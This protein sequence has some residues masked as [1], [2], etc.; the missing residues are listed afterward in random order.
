MQKTVFHNQSVLDC[1]LQQTGS[2]KKLF[3]FAV[4]NNTS[5]TDE[6]KAGNVFNFPEI[7]DT[8]IFNYFNNKK[9][10]PATALI[11]DSVNDTETLGIGA[12]IIETSFIV[13]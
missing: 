2:L 10:I 12:M 4:N 8:D 6:L 13:R 5:I 1:T 3:E 11:D 9:I 7:D